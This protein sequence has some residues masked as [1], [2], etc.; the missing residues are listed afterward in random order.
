MSL[1]ENFIEILELRYGVREKI[2]SKFGTTAFGEIAGELCI[3]NSQFSKLISGSATE[4]MYVRAIKN[5]EQLNT[6]DKVFDEKTSLE[7]KVADL[8]E[9]SLSSESSLSLKIIVTALALLS[10]LFL[11]LWLTN[12]NVVTA[13]S[14]DTRQ[15]ILSEFF[16][17]EYD[18][19]YV[20]PYLLKSDVQE[21]CPC[22]AFEGKWELHNS[23]TLPLP[24]LK[25]GLYYKAKSDKIRIKC[26]QASENRGQ[27]M[28]GFEDMINEVWIDTRRAPVSP[29]FYNVKAN[30]FTKEF[31]MLDFENDP[32]FL[33]VADIRTFIISKFSF[34]ESIII[35]NGEPYGR[36][37]TNINEEVVTKYKID[38]KEILRDIA[39]G[40]MT[41]SCQPSVND[42]CNPNELSIGSSFDFNCWFT[43]NEVYLGKGGAYPYRKGYKLVEQNYSDN[44]FCTCSEDQ[45]S[46]V[47][48]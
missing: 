40:L 47:K 29:K 42:F 27:E 34:E 23:Y 16:D 11:Y 33:R 24:S 26:T 18:A 39:S 48:D 14:G 3:S 1:Q 15:H 35:R 44:L 10:L 41:T 38:I 36:F 25:P 30:N 12:K 46:A 7:T 21:Y 31:Y 28:L 2:T 8:E 6:H 13:N 20:S 5:V 4:G 37:V 17:Q 43:L 22:S 32:Q 19:A 45:D 9:N